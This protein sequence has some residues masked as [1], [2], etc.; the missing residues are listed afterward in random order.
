MSSPNNREGLEEPLLRAEARGEPPRGASNGQ[1]PPSYDDLV[2]PQPDGTAAGLPRR[3]RG[4]PRTTT[5]STTTRILDRDAPFFQSRG[6][7]R[8][9]RVQRGATVLHHTVIP[10]EEADE[11]D[12]D[13]GNGEPL[14]VS[15]RVWALKRFWDN[16]F[17]S[18][19]YQRTVVLMLTLF[20]LYTSIVFL[21]AFVYLFVSTMGQKQI[22]EDGSVK[23]LPFC[24]MDINNHM[25]ALFFSLVRTYPALRRKGRIVTVTKLTNLSLIHYTIIPPSSVN[26]VN[27]RVRCFRLLLWRLLDSAAVGVGTGVVCHHL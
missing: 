27:H 11:D 20:L 18:L 15:R 21:F 7:W 19:A 17:Y 2:A 26:H 1:Q 9:Q 14:L 5:A 24:D 22:E 12:E 16:W 25:E 8:V 23:T 4:R 3:R 6:R 10:E 13:D